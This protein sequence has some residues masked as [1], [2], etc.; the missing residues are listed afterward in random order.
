MPDPAVIANL[1]Q[2][3]GTDK[4]FAITIFQGDGV[5][6]QDLSSWSAVSFIVHAYG[7]PRIV[8]ITK[9]VGS[10]VA[11]TTPTQGLITVTIDAADTANMPPNLY[12]W[13]LERTDSANDVVTGFGTYS[14]LAK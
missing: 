5:T 4:R 6:R 12:Q 13:R 2:Y 11:F 14:L 10:G 7:D 9:T 3:I 1:F 8:F